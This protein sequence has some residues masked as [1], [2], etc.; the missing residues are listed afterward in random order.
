MKGD[1]IEEYNILYPKSEFVYVVPLM[2]TMGI[3]I[4]LWL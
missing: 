3:L 1:M 4:N 2:I